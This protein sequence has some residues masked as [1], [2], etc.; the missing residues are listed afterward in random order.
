MTSKTAGPRLA[1]L[2]VPLITPFRPD[3]AVDAGA[4]EALA[5]RVLDDGADGLVALGTT[6]E[7]ATLS[8]ASGSRCCRSAMACAV[9]ARPG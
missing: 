5:C 6:A 1:G 3:G 4:L 9:T 8:S 2:F 7:T